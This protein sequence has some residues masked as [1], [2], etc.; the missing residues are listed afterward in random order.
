MVKKPRLLT[1]PTLAAT[2]PSHLESGK[3]DSSPL[4]APCP[5]QG[6]N[7]RRGDAR[8]KLV[9]LFNILFID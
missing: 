8:M 4:D 1:R 6:R 5:E 2:P 3:I 7:E 9:D